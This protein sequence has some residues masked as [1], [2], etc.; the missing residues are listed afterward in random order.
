MSK[1]NGMQIF[2]LLSDLNDNLIVESV[3][4]ALLAGG[5]TAAAAVVTAGAKASSAGAV[6][7]TAKTG[8]GAWLAKGG[9]VALLA[10]VLVAAAVAVGM[11]IAGRDPAGT[12]PTG[13]DTVTESESLT[14]ESA[15]S[16]KSETEAPSEESTEAPAE[17]TTDP[18]EEETYSQGLKFASNKDGTCYV[19]GM[20]DC[21]DTVVVIPPVSPAGDKVTGIG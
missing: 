8:L 21:T 2:E 12:P 19:M 11:G 1:L 20:G 14:E 13:E 6:S 7:A 5:A 16:A 9:W 3:A 18:A 17:E 15:E 4:P 10:G